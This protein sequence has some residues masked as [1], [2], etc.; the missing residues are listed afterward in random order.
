MTTTLHTPGL[1][2]GDVAWHGEL[3]RRAQKHMHRGY[4]RHGKHNADTEGLAWACVMIQ[5]CG[6]GASTY[7]KTARLAKNGENGSLAARNGTERHVTV[8]ASK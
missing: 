7:E 3:A 2:C 6:T 4:E 1:F 8:H 5:R